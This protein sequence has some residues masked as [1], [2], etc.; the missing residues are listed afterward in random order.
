MANLDVR[1]ANQVASVSVVDADLGVGGR[2]LLVLSGIAITDWKLDS[3]ELHAGE[4]QV[5]LAVYARNLEQWSAF[6]G[7]ASIGN[8]E[9][10][11]VFA[12]DSARV[13]LDPYTGE[14]ILYFNTAILGEWSYLGR[15]SYQ[16]VATVVRVTPHIPGRITWEKELFTPPSRDI[17][18]VAGE[19]VVLA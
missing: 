10:E 17:S 6:V 1:D 4:N 7:L 12:A 2:R 15:V 11:F 19:L 9:T 3:D 8:D 16:V 13:G 5:R 18:T 14:L